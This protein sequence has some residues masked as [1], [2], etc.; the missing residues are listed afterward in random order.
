MMTSP[1]S[2]NFSNNLSFAQ[3]QS[4]ALPSWLSFDNSTPSISMTNPDTSGSDTYTITNTYTGVSGSSI[5]LTTDLNITVIDII[6][7]NSTETNSTETNST[8]TNS[9]E[10]NSTETNSTETN[11]TETNSTVT[12]NTNPNSSNDDKHCF[13]LSSGTECG[14]VI[15]V[16]VLAFV[17]F[18]IVIA[19]FIHY[20]CK[21]A[22]NRANRENA[23]PVCNQ[24]NPQHQSVQQQDHQ[25]LD[26]QDMDPETEAR[27]INED[28]QIS[29]N[30][31]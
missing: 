2:G 20:N 5:A 18:I 21:K 11:S 24:E 23:R 28:G 30:Q 8:E 12:N 14:I 13:G 29:D 19:V 15:T 17:I 22:R 7:P 25:P 3:S 6:A 10:T 16:I 27:G 4:N 26:I 31:P 9:T 1:N